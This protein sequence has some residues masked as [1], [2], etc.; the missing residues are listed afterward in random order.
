M[1]L[2]TTDSSKSFIVHLSTISSIRTK[3]TI[4]SA[5]M[6]ALLCHKTRNKDCFHNFF[7]FIC[8]LFIFSRRQPRIINCAKTVLTLSHVKKTHVCENFSFFAHFVLTHVR[9]Y[10]GMRPRFLFFIFST[11]GKDEKTDEV[12]KNR[13]FHCSFFDCYI[14]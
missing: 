5:L 2:H 14:V 3:I 8:M 10:F 13:D 9:V 11:S 1:S 6:L 12:T 7:I 4:K